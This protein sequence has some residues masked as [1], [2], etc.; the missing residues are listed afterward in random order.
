MVVQCLGKVS[1]FRYPRAAGVRITVA[2]PG[3]AA[4]NAAGTTVPVCG[5]IV[6]HA[7]TRPSTACGRRS[8]PPSVRLPGT[9]ESIAASGQEL[10][11]GRISSVEL[12]RTA[13]D[14]IE[15]HNTAL[16]AVVTVTA[17]LALE[18]AR[19]A[20]RELRAGRDRGPLHGIP[21]G[22]KDVID[23]RGVRTTMGSAFCQDY[24][25]AR[26]AT[27]V[28]WLRR[29]GAVMI[30]K[31][32]TQEFAY[33]AT[34]ADSFTG[35]AR[36][37]HDPGRIAGG[38]SSGPAAAVAAGLCYAAVGTDTGGSIRIPAA[39]CGVVGLKPTMGRVGRTGVFPLS[40]T[41]DHVGPMTR[42]VADNAA[43]L[44]AISG[45]GPLA[46][47]GTRGLRVGIPEAYF[48]HLDPEVGHQV[49][50]ALEAWAQA[51]AMIRP[52]AVP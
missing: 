42:S 17:E 20:D 38:S 6:I 12:T 50:T 23:V 45:F 11:S 2:R 47:A 46:G 33:G 36:N 40:W 16:N 14:R 27:V 48:E 9:A 7:A 28:R 24:V 21:V 30:G 37:P 15:A 43:M 1:H 22:L 13:L 3:Y 4:G 52:V 26:D 5:V 31:L 32:H 35:P 51:G 18:A 39:L 34:G 29:A 44:T 10:R 19:R 49:G 41:L 25:A 8:M